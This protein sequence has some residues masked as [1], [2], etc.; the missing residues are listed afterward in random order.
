MATKLFSTPYREESHAKLD[1]ILK[2][3]LHPSAECREDAAAGE[4]SVWDGPEVRL[5]PE[6]PPKPIGERVAALFPD[7]VLDVLAEKI[8]TRLGAI[9]KG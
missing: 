4:F 9:Q 3:G 5:V 2:S 1:E 7:E 8:A 6:S